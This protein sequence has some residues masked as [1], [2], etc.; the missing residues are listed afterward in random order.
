MPNRSRGGGSAFGKLRL[1][2]LLIVVMIAVGYGALALVQCAKNKS[3][4]A[5]SAAD[6]PYAISTPSR[7]Y[8]A[9]DGRIQGVMAFSQIT[10]SYTLKDSEVAILFDWYDSEQKDWVHH[11]GESPPLNKNAYGEIAIKRRE[12]QK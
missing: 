4:E 2:C 7:V 1:G 9:S 10:S 5:P 3:S 12:M 8:F 11:K 6:A